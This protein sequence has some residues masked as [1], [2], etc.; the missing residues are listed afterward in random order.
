MHFQHLAL[1][2]FAACAAAP[3]SSVRGDDLY[4]DGKLAAHYEH[5][6][7]DPAHHLDTCKPYHHIYAPDGRLLSKGLGGLFEHHRGMFIGWNQI[8]AGKETWDVWHCRKGEVM[9]HEGYGTP[10]EL[11]LVGDWQVAKVSWRDGKDNVLLREQRAMKADAIAPGTTRF[12]VVI[13]LAAEVP[14]KLGSDPQHSGHQFRALQQFAEQDAVPTRYL[15]P[16]TAKAQPEDVWTDCD[17]LAQVLPFADGAVTILRVEHAG[18]PSP[19]LSSTRP[20][21]RFGTTF[22][23][24]LVPNKPLRLH[25]TYLVVLGELDAARCAALVDEER[26]NCKVR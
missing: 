3:S 10:A 18:N 2:L 15:R 16:A 24:D 17:W 13:E 19:V 8:T 12:D 6:V 7:H 25:Y 1:C 5:P 20:Y 22:A 11:G 14:L 23:C 26:A 4:V 9:R 21:G